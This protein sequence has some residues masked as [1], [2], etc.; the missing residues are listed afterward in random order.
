MKKTLLRISAILVTMLI[1]LVF[2]ASAVV[3]RADRLQYEENIN[4]NTVAIV[5]DAGL[6][7][8]S[9]KAGLVESMKPVAEFCCVLLLTTNS[10]SMSQEDYA[11]QIGEQIFGS[12]VSFTVFLIDMDNRQIYIGS[13]ADIRKT[14]TTARAHTITD[15]IYQYASNGDY[16]TCARVAFEQMATVLNGGKIPE[17]MKIIGCALIALIGG[18]TVCYMIMSSAGKIKAATVAEIETGMGKNDITVSN[19]H[20]KKL[21]SVFV[22][23]AKSGGS[24]GGGFGGGGGGGFSGGGGGGGFGGG[25]H[26][27]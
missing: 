9:D 12:N 11:R 3:T 1:M 21:S 20:K 23:A 24:S 10:N 25:G 5:D 15:N 27:F 26:G 22:A 18:L 16:A 19:V 6:I 8:E 4:G 14:L 13:T 2:L 17:P 7:A